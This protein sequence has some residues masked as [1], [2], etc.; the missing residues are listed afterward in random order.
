M[1]TTKLY[2]VRHGQTT[3]NRDGLISGYFVDP[4][5][6]EQG[7]TQA[8]ETKQKLSHVHFDEAYSSDLQRAAHTAAIIYGQDIHPTKQ[9]AGLRERTFGAIEGKP[10]T[11]LDEFR[12]QP[13]FQSLSAEERWRHKF[14][15]DM[16]SDHEVSTR[17]IG[18]LRKIANDNRGKTVLIAAHGGTLRTL[19]ISIGYAS[20]AELP[21]GTIDNAAFVE[22]DYDDDSFTTGEV[23][24]IRKAI[25]D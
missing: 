11:L 1:P 20:S 16:E 8:N 6:T 3:H 21:F 19:L 25:V 12:L 17:F 9:M 24:G 15:D 18:A 23:G 5:L 10:N 7:I 22:L 4:V 2:V 13:H 14:K